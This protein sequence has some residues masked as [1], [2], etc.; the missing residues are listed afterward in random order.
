MPT[1]LLH[2]RN[3]QSILQALQRTPSSQ[4]LPEPVS[5]Q[6]TLKVRQVF[7]IIQTQSES[8]SY[9]TLCMCHFQTKQNKSKYTIYIYILFLNT[10]QIPYEFP[11]QKGMTCRSAQLALEK[12]CLVSA[13]MLTMCS[14]MT[15]TRMLRQP[16]FRKI[17][18]SL[19]GWICMNEWH[20]ARVNQGEPVIDVNDMLPIFPDHCFCYNGTPTCKGHTE[21]DRM[22]RG[23][24]AWQWWAERLS[25]EAGP[26]GLIFDQS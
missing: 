20:T 15:A 9:S 10:C 13:A 25:L 14:T 5:L 4:P 24:Q 16:K 17:T 23:T 6:F 21:G 7:I 12:L 11:T 26:A 19:S 18:E 3:I 8:S 1:K 22:H 2:H